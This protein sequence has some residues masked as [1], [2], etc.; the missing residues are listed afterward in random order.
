MTEI[1]EKVNQQLSRLSSEEERKELLGLF[2]SFMEECC[3]AECKWCKEGLP[4]SKRKGRWMHDPGG[5]Y[6]RNCDADNIRRH[7][8][9]LEKK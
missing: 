8:A 3:K 9:W 7:Y 6:Y 4:I 5:P 2:R 1:Q